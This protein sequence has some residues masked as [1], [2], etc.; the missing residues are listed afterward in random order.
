MNFHIKLQDYFSE[1]PNSE[2]SPLDNPDEKIKRLTEAAALKA[3]VV[4]ATLSAPGGIVGIISSL[5]D[6]AAI[7]R[8]Q[9]QLVADIAAVYGKLGYLTKQSLV[10]CLCKQSGFQIARDVAVRA[11]T[12]MLL[13]KAPLKTLSRALPVLGAVSSGAYAAFDTYGVSK[14]AKA[15]FGS[16]QSGE[17]SQI[18]PDL[19]Q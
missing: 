12:H 18:S 4:S 9:A 11:G 14:I 13:K 1:V 19:P 17:N 2:L 7:W 15:Y 10:W 5:P 3:A 16:I 8:I 6:L